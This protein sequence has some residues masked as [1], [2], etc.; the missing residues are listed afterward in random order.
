[1]Y[2]L[3]G[4]TVLDPF[5]GTG[6]TAIAAIVAGRNSIGYEIDSVFKD[7]IHDNI[8]NLNIDILNNIIKNRLENHKEFIKD[9][10]KD[11]TKNEIKHFNHVLSLPVITSQETGIEFS[12]INE[13][14]RKPFY[15]EVIYT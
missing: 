12:F 4:D 7:V 10:S 14:V 8:K 11:K 13:I 3:K 6:T 9:R 1:M 2:S 15:F 5:M